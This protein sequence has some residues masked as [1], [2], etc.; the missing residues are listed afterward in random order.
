M[1]LAFSGTINKAQGQTLQKVG[2]YFQ[3]PC[4]A[5]GQLYVFLSRV[6]HPDFVSITI[7]SILMVLTMDLSHVMLYTKRLSS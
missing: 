7:L 4:F 3:Q 6:G 2:G 1:S 5:H